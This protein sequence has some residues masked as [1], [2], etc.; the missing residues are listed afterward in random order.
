MLNLDCTTKADISRA[1]Y[2]PWK[3]RANNG[4]FFQ[5]VI[6]QAISL[7]KIVKL[8]FLDHPCCRRID[9]PA[10]LELQILREHNKERRNGSSFQGILEHGFPLPEHK[11]SGSAISKV[12]QEKYTQ[13]QIGI[14]D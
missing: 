13:I 11:V 5:E 2:R 9:R 7:Q 14:G 8:R 1:D 12:I 6:C 3:N 4:Q 10:R